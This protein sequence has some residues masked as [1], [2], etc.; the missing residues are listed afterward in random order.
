MESTG[1]TTSKADRKENA[2]PKDHFKFI[3]SIHEQGLGEK[4][5]KKKL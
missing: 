4:Q 2:I 5:N 3:P 1:S